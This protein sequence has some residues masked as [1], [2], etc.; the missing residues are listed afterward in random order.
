MTMFIRI[1]NNAPVG[2][3][4]A[5]ENFR[6]LFPTTSFPKHFTADV[7]E[8]LGYGI[9][10]FSNHPI[11]NRYEKAIEVAAVRSDAGIWRQTWNVVEMDVTEKSEADALKAQAVRGERDRMLFASDWIVIRAQETGGSISAEWAAYRQ[12]LRDITA[13]ANFPHLTEDDWPVKP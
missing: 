6:Q 10:D 2:F 1:E 3:P 12:A 13:H 11:L 4:I 7:V 8:P 9:Y 5:E